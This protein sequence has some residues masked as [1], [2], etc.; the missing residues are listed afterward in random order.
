MLPT[1]LRNRICEKFKSGEILRGGGV[2]EVKTHV[3]M[4]EIAFPSSRKQKFPGP[5]SQTPLGGS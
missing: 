1:G 5:C 2:C 3:R 4:R